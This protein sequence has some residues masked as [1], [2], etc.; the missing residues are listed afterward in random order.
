MTLMDTQH[1]D[2]TGSTEAGAEVVDLLRP[3][4]GLDLPADA[5]SLDYHGG[6]RAAVAM[7]HAGEIDR[8]GFFELCYEATIGDDPNWVHLG[9]SA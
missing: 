6:V 8:L 4:A 9:E 1:T 2:V 5:E 3:T 7:L